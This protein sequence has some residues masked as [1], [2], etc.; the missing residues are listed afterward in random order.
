MAD[1]FRGAPLGDDEDHLDLRPLLRLGAWGGCAFAAVAVA[2]TVGMSDVGERRAGVAFAA[3]TG[4]ANEKSLRLSGGE[5]LARA[6]AERETR[7]MAEAVRILAGDRDRLAGRV[8]ALERNLDDLTGSIKR[9]PVI[10]ATPPA[11]PAI[12]SA[13]VP[14][15]PVAAAPATPA[16]RRDEASAPP[17]GASLPNAPQFIASLPSVPPPSPLQQSPPQQNPQP[18]APAPMAARE[19]ATPL[20]PPTDIAAVPATPPAPAATVVPVPRPGPIALIQSYASSTAVPTPPPSA[21]V[22]A[23]PV[24]AAQPPVADAAASEPITAPATIPST[25]Y[26]VDLG[27]ASSVNGLRALWDRSKARQPTQLT[28][29]RPLI[30]VRD[31]VRP[32]SAELRLVAGPLPSAGAAARL[33]AALT[34]AGVHCQPAVF[35]GQ[36]LA[37]R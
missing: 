22:T 5:L 29:L 9:M 8:A 26:A 17:S 11:N 31:G 36:R 25:E 37:L 35:D 32:G 4:S 13:P 6:D 10:A 2:V 23:P 28:G 12:T 20:P 21:A 7:R 27:A 15:A 34:I 30:S 19:A 16:S 18:Q 3:L 24:A 33:C 1:N 14:P